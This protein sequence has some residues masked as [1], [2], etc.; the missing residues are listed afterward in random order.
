[1]IDLG[2]AAQQMATLLD[3]VTDDQLSAPTPC[4]D[5]RLGDL[6]DHIGG[7]AL[8]FT[9]AATKDPS[10]GEQAPS[11]DAARLE[12]GW[13]TRITDQLTALAE[14][15]RAPEAWQGMT[16]AGGIDLPGDVAGRVAVDELVLHGWD[17]ARA[18]GQSFEVDPAALQACLEFVTAMST[19]DQ[20]SRDGLFGPI[21]EVP[22]DRPLLE[23][24]LG[25][26]GRNPAWT[27]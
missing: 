4:P 2:P 25:L 14:A 18:T 11:G 15:W 20:E 8:A 21:V 17:V 22:A 5:Y 26:S 1:M 9:A 7:L 16:R 10:M 19:E 3:N 6:I 13:R 23:R 27:A 12:P 24:V